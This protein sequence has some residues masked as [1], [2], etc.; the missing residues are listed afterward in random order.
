MSKKYCPN[1]KQNVYTKRTGGQWVM[2]GVFALAAQ[3]RCPICN[4]PEKELEEPRD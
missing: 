3:K 4:F 2:G 1:C